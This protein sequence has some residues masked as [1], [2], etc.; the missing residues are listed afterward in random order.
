MGELLQ[1][2]FFSAGVLLGR[3]AFSNS[4]MMLWSRIRL[5]EKFWTLGRRLMS[6]RPK[7][8][9]RFGGA[10]WRWGW[11]FRRWK[12]TRRERWAPAD[13]RC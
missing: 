6:Y 3:K 12:D 4:V 2:C 5:L 11:A 1:G 7:W 9:R 8:R 10:R 13:W